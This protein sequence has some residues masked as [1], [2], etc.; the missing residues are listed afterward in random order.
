MTMAPAPQDGIFGSTSRIM[1]HGDPRPM[2]H[3][4]GEPVVAG[5]PPDDDAAFARSLGDG[6]DSGQ[7]AQRGVIAP[8]Q[9]IPSLCEQ[10][11]EDDP[12]YSR[13]GFIK[14]DKPG[15][16]AYVSKYELEAAKIEGIKALHRVSYELERHPITQRFVA[17]K[18]RLLDEKQQAAQ[19]AELDL[20]FRTTALSDMYNLRLVAGREVRGGREPENRRLSLPFTHR[21][22]DRP[23]SAPSSAPSRWRLDPCQT[24]SRS[25]C[26]SVRPSRRV[27]AR[28]RNRFVAAVAEDVVFA[29]ITPDGSLPNLAEEV[30]G[31]RI[32]PRVLQF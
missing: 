22:R 16:D 32:E 18:I 25:T 15:S 12:S 9:G 17:T 2:L 30:R 20:V 8:L 23:R 26:S 21:A 7:A 29:F 10:R 4:V 28:K 11:G 13:H 5:L 24:H 3:G 31:W 14:P 1:L 19:R 27:P 6:R